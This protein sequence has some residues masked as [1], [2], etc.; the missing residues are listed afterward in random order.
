MYLKVSNVPPKQLLPYT[1][2]KGHS[3][4]GVALPYVFSE[5]FH[6]GENTSVTESLQVDACPVDT[7]VGN[8][9]LCLS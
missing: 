5:V 7:P 2:E 1:N 3:Q 9:A 4:S 8:N 6:R